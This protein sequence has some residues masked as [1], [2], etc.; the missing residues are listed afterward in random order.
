MT[1]PQKIVSDI[2]GSRNDQTT[3]YFDSEKIYVVCGC[4]RGTL[5]EFKAKVENSYPKETDCE[6]GKSYR[7]FISKVE[8]YLNDK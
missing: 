7:K 1:N 5:N 6:H 4:F 2:I 8:R 3:I